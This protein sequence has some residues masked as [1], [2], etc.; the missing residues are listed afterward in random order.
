MVGCDLYY[1]CIDVFFVLMVYFSD[2]NVY[3][4]GGVE[5]VVLVCSCSV[6]FL[7]VGGIVF[8]DW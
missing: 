1:V 6:V 5:G 2:I 4:C 7:V 8:V 3:Y